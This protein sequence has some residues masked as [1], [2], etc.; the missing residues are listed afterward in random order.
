[1]KKP[2]VALM[3]LS[4]ML[5]MPCISHAQDNGLIILPFSGGDQV[6]GYENK[7]QG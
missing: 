1:M 4:W 7:D 3:L 6:V 2:I 5:V